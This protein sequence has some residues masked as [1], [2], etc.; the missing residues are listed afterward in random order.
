MSRRKA[1]IILIVTAAALTAVTVALAATKHFAFTGSTDWLDLVSDKG[2][3]DL[4]WFPF[5][6]FAAFVLLLA[7]VFRG[8]AGASRG[9]TALA[10]GL[11]ALGGFALHLSAGRVAPG[12]SAEAAL[13]IPRTNIFYHNARATTSVGAFLRSYEGRAEEAPVMATRTHPPGPELFYYFLRR[14][15]RSQPWLRDAVLGA[16]E[17]IDSPRRGLD[18]PEVRALFSGMAMDRAEV[19]VVCCLAF[20]FKLLACLA[21]VPT[22][23]LGSALHSRRTG[24]MAAAWVAVLPGVH[25]FS[26]GLDQVYPLFAATMGWLALVAV[27]RRSAV[28]GSLFGLLL[29]ISM[30]FTLAFVVAA[31]LVGLVVLASLLRFRGGRSASELFRAYAPVA[32]AALLG[33]AVVVA[34]FAAFWQVNLFSVWAR[35][36]RENAR[37]NVMSRRSY[38]GSIVSNPVEFFVFLGL[39]LACVFVLSVGRAVRVVRSAWLPAAGVLCLAALMLTLNLTGTNRG[40]VARLW[41][42]I[43]PFCAVAGAWWLEERRSAWWPFCALLALQMVQVACFRAALDALSLHSP[44]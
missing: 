10:V 9:A 21:V 18:S 36:L 44:R 35:C 22:Y 8:A 12:G 2:Q 41:M 3:W 39:P 14:L 15:Y 7:V 32:A 30:L 1:N 23:L 43:M 27:R 4:L 40:E 17:S 37:F 16:W 42:F 26:P 29:C 13:A 34:A 11:L 19:D 38:L 28:V 25:C 5:A 33:F 31:A 20:T 6:Y 24:L